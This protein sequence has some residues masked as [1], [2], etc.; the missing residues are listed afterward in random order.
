M[1]RKKPPAGKTAKSRSP[2]KAKRSAATAAKATTGGQG[3]GIKAQTA[4]LFL[5]GGAF[6]LEELLTKTKGKEITVRTAIYDLRS[7]KYAGP[8]GALNIVLA[9]GRYSLV[10]GQQT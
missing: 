2:R 10:K 3:R 7:P 8:T 1:S 4:A 6:T 9:D 5:S